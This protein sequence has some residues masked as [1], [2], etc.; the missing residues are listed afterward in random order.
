MSL[1]RVVE[2]IRP[3]V[4]RA[5]K[6]LAQIRTLFRIVASLISG[7]NGRKGQQRFYRYWTFSIT[8]K[9]LPTHAQPVAT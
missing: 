6:L 5:G 3:P 7:N 9:K 8:Y 2:L 4:S 1:R